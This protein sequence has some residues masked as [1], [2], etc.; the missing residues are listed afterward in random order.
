MTAK[1]Y[2][3]KV[4][5]AAEIPFTRRQWGGSIGGPI[6][7]NRMF[8]FGANENISEDN[9][10]PVPD[11]LYRE[12]QLLVN[13]MNAG[14][15]P[16]G[17][18]NPNHPQAGPIPM[19]LILYTGKASA[20][21]NNDHAVMVR[22]AGQHDDRDAVTFGPSNDLREP[23]NSSIRMWSAVG[24][25]NWVLS[26]NGLNQITGQVNHLY[27]L[28]DIVSAVT[29]EHYRRDFPNVP[30]FPPRLSFPS[31]NTGAGGAGG[32]LTDAYV[33]QFK[34]EVSLLKGQ[35]TLKFGVNYNNLPRLGL[36]NANEHFAT[37]A[38]FDDPSVILN[39]SN[40]RYPQGFRTP[41]IVRQWQ[42]ANTVLSTTWS[43]A[44]RSNLRSGFRM[45]GVRPRSSR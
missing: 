18:V 23:E 4:Q 12:K 20:Q 15:I 34:D 6:L 10:D 43:R 14:L 2:F 35:Q 30:L 8:F 45:I 29:G 42:Q 37:L 11:A 32:S 40:G 27:R 5:N 44:A 17:L 31:V 9:S 38:F 33:I 16:Q 1:D 41:G 13:A 24:Q 36:A 19:S 7:R 25:H 22:Y 26:N 39:N 21:L 3:T 28:S